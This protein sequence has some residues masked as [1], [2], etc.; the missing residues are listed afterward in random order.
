VAH[1]SKRKRHNPSFCDAFFVEDPEPTVSFGDFDTAIQAMH[2]HIR[3]SVIAPQARG[4]PCGGWIESGIGLELEITPEAVMHSIT[5]PWLAM[6]SEWPQR[7][8]RIRQ[9]AV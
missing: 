4:R 5:D 8:R 6:P 9:K 3:Q 7:H 2:E 1:V